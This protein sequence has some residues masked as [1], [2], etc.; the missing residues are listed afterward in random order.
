[1]KSLV[2]IAGSIISLIF[3]SLQA[4]QAA[5]NPDQLA[6]EINRIIASVDPNLNVG[7]AVKSMKYN[8]ALY[9]HNE[10]RSFMPA[11]ILKV[12]TA[13]AALIH[14]G[15][16]YTFPTRF[17]TDAKTV[18]NGTLHGNLYLTLSGDP[19]LTYDD[20]AELMQALKARNIQ[21]IGGN[22]YIDITAYDNVLHGPG[23]PD[24]DK[25][26][27][28]AAPI[29]ASII[30]KNCL[31]F[32][33]SPNR[34]VGYPATIVENARYGYSAIAND[35]ITKPSSAR[36][37]IRV[38]SNSEQ[39]ITVSGCM[40]KGRYSQDVTAII[41]EVMGYNRSLVR[42]LFRSHNIAVSG[43]ITSGK[44]PGG[45][46]I[47]AEHRSAPLQQLV[48]KML[49]KSDN[50]IAGTLFKKVGE[51]FSKRQGTWESG[52]QA[53]SAILEQ[54][55]GVNADQMRVLDGSGLSPQNRVTPAQML[56][57]LDYAFHD[58]ATNYH[59][60][61]GLPVAGIDGTLKRRLHNT[62]WKV[63]A[64]TGYI[65]GVNSLAGYAMT[66]NK[67]P[68]AFVIIVNGRHGMGWKYKAMEDKI[69]TAITQYSRG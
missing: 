43:Q 62:A 26:Y 42:S 47:L 14:L 9:M 31:N 2:N 25:N 52:R 10:H 8:D 55:A 17:Y 34:T 44:M 38:G 16:S 56:Q 41:N 46:P 24:S 29:S 68:L 18:S 57:V 20:F 37:S 49:K 4:A 13:E 27:C 28:Y 32:S 11:S 59:F 53:V 64:K 66:R 54:K 67:E 69:V 39:G 21:R 30:N 1:M 61:S 7:V 12:L 22:I 19:T 58:H 5:T 33:I 36:C 48:N 65:S 40:P 6:A 45:L 35:V 23:L 50:V 60:V 51:T 3:L 15:P 63:R